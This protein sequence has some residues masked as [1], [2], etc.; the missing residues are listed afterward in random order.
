MTPE[1]F[2]QNSPVLQHKIPNK[3]YIISIEIVKHGEIL[4]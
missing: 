1:S 3:C 4:R 2:G